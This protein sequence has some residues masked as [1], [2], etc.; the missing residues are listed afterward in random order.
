MAEEVAPPPLTAEITRRFHLFD[1]LI[2]VA[3]L[4]LGLSGIRD[5]I[6]T[7]IPRAYWWHQEL[8]S[9]QN[10]VISVPPLD[11]KELDFS[12]RSLVVQASDEGQAWFMSV[13]IGLTPAQILLRLRRPRPGWCVLFRQPG[14]MACLA[15]V[16][17]YLIDRGWDDSI[18]PGFA[19]FPFWTALSVLVVWAILLGLK[20]CRPEQSWIDRLGRTLGAGWV[21]AGFW[22][23]LEEYYFW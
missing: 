4:G 5:R 8:E 1:A 6:L 11:Q 2:L 20:R 22:S 18:R 12:L 3:A 15:A 23:Q 17:G 9:Y 16:A 13:L 7:L 14:F 21:V 19:P 10:D